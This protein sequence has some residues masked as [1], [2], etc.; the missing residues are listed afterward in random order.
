MNAQF[1]AQLRLAGCPLPDGRTPPTSGDLIE[2]CGELVDRVV[3]ERPAAEWTAFSR[4]GAFYS[5][6]TPEDALANLW[7]STHQQFNREAMTTNENRKR[8]YRRGL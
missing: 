8:K 6:Q 4:D 2:A 7:L 1:L 3:W 5:G